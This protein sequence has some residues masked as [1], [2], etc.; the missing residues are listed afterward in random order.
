VIY[1]KLNLIFNGEMAEKQYPFCMNA[2]ELGVEVQ[3]H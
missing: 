1:V 2:K 3:L